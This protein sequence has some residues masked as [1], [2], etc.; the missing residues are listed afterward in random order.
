MAQREPPSAAQSLYPNLPSGG[1]PEV[2]QRQ[3]NIADAMWPSLSREAKAKEA[4]QS[5][6]QEW[7]RREQKESNAR[8]VE[9]LRAIN[10]RLRQER[11]R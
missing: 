6:A 11:G 5:W 1:R 2:K 3:P 4:S 9:R 7:A 8:M 10:E